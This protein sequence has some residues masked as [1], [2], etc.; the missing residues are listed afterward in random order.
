M[1]T[2]CSGITSASH[3]E[4]PGFKSQW[5][6]DCHRRYNLINIEFLLAKLTIT[7]P[8]HASRVVSRLCVAVLRMSPELGGA[9]PHVGG[10]IF[11][12]VRRGC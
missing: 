2:W 8:L 12:V 6:Q 3:A 10:V 9:L 5:V 1:G 7:D 11:G 4:G